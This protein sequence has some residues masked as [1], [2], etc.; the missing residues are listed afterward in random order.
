M[1][2]YGSTEYEANLYLSP[3]RN[4]PTRSNGTALRLA[5]GA[6]PHSSSSW[7][8]MDLTSIRADLV[9]FSDAIGLGHFVYFEPYYAYTEDSYRYPSTI[10]RYD[11]RG[12]FSDPASWQLL[13][14]PGG[15]GG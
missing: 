14:I 8:R 5:D 9:G 7:E 4:R 11:T 15:V 2:Y 1:G 12:G 6:D 13:D 3:Y 10:A